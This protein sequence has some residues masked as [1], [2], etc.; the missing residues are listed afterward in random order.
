[1]FGKELHK[2]E[3]YIQ[4]KRYAWLHPFI[5]SPAPSFVHS[6]LSSL[7]PSKKKHC[8]IYGKWTECLWSVE[9]QVYEAH[10]KTEKKADKKLKNV[11]KALCDVFTCSIYWLY[12]LE[13]R[14]QFSLGHQIH[15]DWQLCIKPLLTVTVKL[16]VSRRNLK[17]QRTTKQTT[18]LKSRRRFLLYQ[19]ALCCGGLTL[20]HHYLLWYNSTGTTQIHNNCNPENKFSSQCFDIFSNKCCVA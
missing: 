7:L 15:S 6:S 20:D 4:D 17:G 13:L 18:C 19:E 5:L 12:V 8:I 3:G 2:V 14:I 1:M 10:R 11:R 16:I 9:P